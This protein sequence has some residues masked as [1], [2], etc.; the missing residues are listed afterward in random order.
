MYNS[1]TAVPLGHDRTTICEKNENE[2]ADRSK[3]E[4]RSWWGLDDRDEFG[5]LWTCSKQ[6]WCGRGEIGSK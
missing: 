4:V 2:N 1:N 6:S 5:K 3:V